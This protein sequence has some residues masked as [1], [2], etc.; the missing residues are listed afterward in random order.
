MPRDDD[1]HG[2]LKLIDE[3]EGEWKLPIS[4]RAILLGVF[5]TSSTTALIWGLIEEKRIDDKT[6][7]HSPNVN[8]AST[9][10][11]TPAMLSG[12]TANPLWT[13]KLP[14]AAKAI[15]VNTGVV[16]VLDKDGRLSGFDAQSGAAKWKPSVKLYSSIA[17]LAVLG[18]TFLGVTADERLQ[19]VGALDGGERWQVQ[20]VD[21]GSN[22]TAPVSQQ[23]FGSTVL[24]TGLTIDVGNRSND[25]ALI[26]GVDTTTHSVA[27]KLSRTGKNPPITTLAV[28]ESAGVILSA[29]TT[30]P[31]LVAYSLADRT[32][33]WRKS[34]NQG[35]YPIDLPQNC[36]TVSG[37]TF[38]WAEYQLHAIDARTG[39]ELWTAPAP[40]PKAI[41]VFQAV[42]LVPRSAPDGG[43]LVVTAMNTDKDNGSLYAFAASTGEQVW[44][45][46]AGKEF[47]SP[48][49][50]L[51]TA[52][53]IIFATESANGSVYAV[54]AKTGTTR[55]TFHDPT[56]DAPDWLTATDGT[57]LYVAYG[58]TLLAFDP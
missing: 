35:S 4:R 14:S 20:L 19:A 42:V 38:Y 47:G 12:P 8:Q 50:A 29:D 56:P 45:R 2:T 37:N 54:D 58:T 21:T 53:G 40:T 11:P 16:A 7:D 36:V 55:W 25:A 17:P 26:W 3:V 1:E 34:P 52:N 48:H 30:V 28:S 51:S 10:S 33:L 31:G 22:D 5:G 27:W 43:D 39:K 44:Q 9:T 24:L 57:R 13:V 15:A 49:S 46:Q 6:R 23:V 18:D 32:E 41:E